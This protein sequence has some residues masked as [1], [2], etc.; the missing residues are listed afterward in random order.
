MPLRSILQMF[1]D[2]DLAQYKPWLRGRIGPV[3]RAVYHALSRASGPLSTGALVKEVYLGQFGRSTRMKRS[4][5]HGIDAAPPKVRR[6][7]Y[8][9]VRIAAQTYANRIG[10]AET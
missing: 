10:R 2:G 7:M 1:N 8:L 3:E 6:W 4:L 5:A 9:R